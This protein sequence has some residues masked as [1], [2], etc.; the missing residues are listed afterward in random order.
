[1]PACDLP[2]DRRGSG[3]ARP[4][5]AP[6]WGGGA[7]GASGGSHH[8]L[9]SLASSSGLNTERNSGGMTSYCL[10]SSLEAMFRK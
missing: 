4:L 2:S 9:P 8:L 7:E 3:F 1:M 5:A 6:P 10:G